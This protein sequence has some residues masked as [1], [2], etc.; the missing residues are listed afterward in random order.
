MVTSKVWALQYSIAPVVPEDSEELLERRK[1]VEILPLYG[2]ARRYS[3][4]ASFGAR[5]VPFVN[6]GEVGSAQVQPIQDRSQWC[7]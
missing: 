6:P 4:P 1:H 7:G 2:V 3:L 5:R